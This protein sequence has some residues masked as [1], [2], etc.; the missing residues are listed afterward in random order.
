MLP[1]TDVC[2]AV[3]Q[4]PNCGDSKEATRTLTAGRLRLKEQYDRTRHGSVVASLE[5][6]FATVAPTTEI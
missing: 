6:G 5:E 1:S 2:R 4:R 3:T